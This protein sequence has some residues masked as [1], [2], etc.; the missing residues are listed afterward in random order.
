LAG[1]NK[2]FMAML[3]EKLMAHG[4]CKIRRTLMNEEEILLEFY[5]M[6]EFYNKTLRMHQ[7]KIKK[8]K[9]I[10]PL[11]VKM[12]TTVNLEFESYQ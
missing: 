8:P 10:Y 6:V 4:K 3:A 5:D 1:K 11:H 12:R 2:R 7:I 9:Y